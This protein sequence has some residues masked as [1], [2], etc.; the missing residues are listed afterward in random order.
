MKPQCEEIAIDASAEADIVAR[1]TPKGPFQVVCHMGHPNPKIGMHGR[2]IFG[3]LDET[4]EALTEII[5]EDVLP[6]LHHLL[7]AAPA[8]LPGYLG[9]GPVGGFLRWRKAIYVSFTPAGA[10]ILSHD[11][12]AKKPL[13]VEATGDLERDIRTWA[14]AHW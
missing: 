7:A 14:A 2:V 11:M 6:R 5:D 8:K 13:P 4:L 10:P 12:R 3:T 9:I 1:R